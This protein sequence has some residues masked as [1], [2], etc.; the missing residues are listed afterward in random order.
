MIVRCS[1]CRRLITLL[2]VAAIAAAIGCDARENARKTAETATPAPSA[3]A[4]P[5]MESAAGTRG[6]RARGS[7]ERGLGVTRISPEQGSDTIELPG[8][9]P[10]DVPLYPAASPTKYI[11]TKSGRT[12][13]TLVVDETPESA[14]SY[15][16]EALEREG[17]EVETN[18]ASDELL[19]VSASKESRRLQ[20]SVSVEKGVTTIK[21]IENHR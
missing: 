8:N 21:L 11:S 20:V 2:A 3:S 19:I 12:S 6:E 16:T 17:W 10:A 5:K 13:T 14:R 18:G 7:V 15:Y 1:Y 9:F 4:T